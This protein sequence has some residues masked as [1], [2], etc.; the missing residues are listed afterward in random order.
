MKY[1]INHNL[2]SNA[3]TSLFKRHRLYWVV[4]GAMSG[5]STICQI[6][7]DRFGIPIYDMDAHIYGTYHSRFTQERHPANYDWS[8][9]HNGLEWLLSMSWGEFNAFNKAALAEYL[10]LMAEDMQ[11]QELETPILVD[12]GICNPGLLTQV[13]PANQIVCLAR[14]HHSSGHIWKENKE[15]RGMK[16]L[17]YKLP[18]PE[19]AWQT[20]LEFDKK[21][22]R[23]IQKECRE[24]S[25]VACIR[26]ENESP[27]NFSAKVAQVLRIREP[28]P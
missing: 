7:S 24:R 16:D 1:R 5:K 19:L 28:I 3:C 20:F 8:S 12:G 17:I 10:D 4:G 2:L 21:I 27:E 23:T 18:K 15:R 14:K 9:A 6:L 26:S 22:T 13:I 11:A 25:I